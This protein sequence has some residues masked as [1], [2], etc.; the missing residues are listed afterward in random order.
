MIAD[1]EA[2]THNAERADYVHEN[3]FEVMCDYLAVGINPKKTTIFLRSQIPELFELTSYFLNLVTLSRL[4]Q[5][6]TIKTEMKE[7]DFSRNVPVG[8][9]TYPISQA[10]DILMFRADV[11]PVGVDQ[12]PMIE[13][14]NEIVLKFNR[15]YGKT[16]NKVKGLTPEVG[17]LSG[18]DGKA[19]MSKS[20]GN[21]I[22]LSDSYEN[23]KRK[24]MM[25]YTDPN[26]IHVD[27]PGKVRGNIVFEY[28]DAFD[29]N[30]KEV[31]KLK[32]Q[33]E[34]GG[35]GDVILKKRLVAVLEE[36]IGPIRKKREKIA[37]NKA[38]VFSILKKGTKDARKFAGETLK[39][40]RKSM[41]LD[42]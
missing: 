28:L 11:V 7:R 17:R 36:I 14:A 23:I 1:T 12:L 6:P 10:A 27:D 20:L 8:F 13:Q 15:F 39:K 3:V 2:L 18:I 4:E 40:V 24:V 38:Q 9:L 22:Y 5:N 26:H 31:L 37:K 19:K 35:L 33:Y 32:R 29:E 34:K 25:M 42:Y 21:A 41:K 16:F 30:K